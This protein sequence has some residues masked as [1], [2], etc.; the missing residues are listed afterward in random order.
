MF[1]KEK[2]SPLISLL[3]QSHADFELQAIFMI[4]GG[5]EQFVKLI[6]LA[7]PYN[8]KY[9]YILNIILVS[10]GSKGSALFT[11]GVGLCNR[12][13]TQQYTCP[14][15]KQICSGLSQDSLIH[16]KAIIADPSR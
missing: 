5:C 2:I 7:V 3:S 4:Q 1:S 16:F 11:V 8:L 9:M 10:L 12:K 6:F 14:V 15:P 13:I